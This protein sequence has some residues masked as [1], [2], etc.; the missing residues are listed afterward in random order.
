VGKIVGAKAVKTK[1][2][3]MTPMINKTSQKAQQ[4]KRKSFQSGYKEKSD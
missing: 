4:K 1:F 2:H 3:Q